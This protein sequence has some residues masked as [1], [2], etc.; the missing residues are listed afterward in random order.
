L[1]YKT[2]NDIAKQGRARKKPLNELLADGIKAISNLE[3]VDLKYLVACDVDTLEIL[4][5]YRLPMVLL[6]AAKFKEVWL[7]DTLVVNV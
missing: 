6:V 4:A 7:I 5:E 3:N 1:L 2:L